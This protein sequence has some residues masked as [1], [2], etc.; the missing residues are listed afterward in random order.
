MDLV[1][2]LVPLAI[3]LPI[4]HLGYDLILGAT[5]YVAAAGFRSLPDF[6]L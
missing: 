1:F 4:Y 5:T 3:L 2:N 6:G